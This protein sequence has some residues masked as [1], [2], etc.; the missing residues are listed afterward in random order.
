VC[1][2][3]ARV[4]VPAFSDVL[5]EVPH[6][7]RECAHVCVCVCVCVYLCVCTCPCVRGFTG[8]GLAGGHSAYTCMYNVVCL[9]CRLLLLSPLTNCDCTSPV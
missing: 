1:S 4:G 9:A 3:L 7:G 5:G 6:T 2:L 8:F